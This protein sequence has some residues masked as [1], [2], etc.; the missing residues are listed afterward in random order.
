LESQIYDSEFTYSTV[1]IN[2]TMRLHKPDNRCG[3][4]C[5]PEDLEPNTNNNI[6]IS[7][8]NT[9]ET[10]CCLDWKNILYEK[11]NLISFLARFSPPLLSGC[12]LRK[13]EYQLL[14]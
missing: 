12:V 4:I 5:H 9:I 10:N 2:Q 11:V 8:L 7:C 13:Y 1:A 6:Y 3:E 14:G